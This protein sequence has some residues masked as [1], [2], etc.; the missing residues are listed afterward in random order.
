MDENI[1]EV[2]FVMILHDAPLGMR[3]ST[4]T[5]SYKVV[6][7]LDA[8]DFILS[9]HKRPLLKLNYTQI[10]KWL[11]NKEECSFSFFYRRCKSEAPS[12]I[13]L[14][15]TRE[16]DK[17]VLDILELTLQ[18]HIALLLVHK[19][20]AENMEKAM[21]MFNPKPVSPTTAQLMERGGA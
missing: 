17:A 5:N 1:A 10:S 7:T 3:M 15:T 19:G 12:F 9:V 21:E 20:M 6:V 14:K 13:T 4:L 11:I 2:K 8:T 18:K 16:K